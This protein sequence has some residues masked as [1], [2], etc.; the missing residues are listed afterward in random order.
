MPPWDSV[1][2][3][4]TL[5]SA[6]EISS[7]PPSDFSLEFFISGHVRPLVTRFRLGSS[8]HHAGALARNP[9]KLSPKYT[10][11]LPQQGTH[12]THTV[13]MRFGKGLLLG[14]LAFAQVVMGEDYYKV[15]LC[16]SVSP[17][18]VYKLTF[19]VTGPRCRQGRNGETD[20]VC[21]QATKQEIPPRQ[22]PVRLSP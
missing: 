17:S 16:R 7:Q 14:L 20:Q 12:T 3:Y 11:R 19:G 18:Q 5:G 10:R 8:I 6:N 4:F 9:L 15:R 2:V 22:E 21:L 13:K 1:K